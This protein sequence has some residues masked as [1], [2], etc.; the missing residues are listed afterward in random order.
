M[1][2]E[3]WKDIK[4][5]EGRYQVSNLGRVK[6]LNYNRQ[7]VSKVLK[8]TVSRTGYLDVGLCKDKVRKT[9]RV[10]R[11]VAEAFIPNPGNKPQVN[12]LDEDKTNNRVDNLEW[13]TARENSNHGTRTKRMS[14]TNSKPIICTNGNIKEKYA[15]QKEFCLKYRFSSGQVSEV[16]SGKHKTVG[17]WTIERA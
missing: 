13:C 16:I 3:I 9:Y 8:N 15:S 4:E 10:H 14:I 7:G 5:Y 2:E 6:S 17:G 1:T 12:H 11:L